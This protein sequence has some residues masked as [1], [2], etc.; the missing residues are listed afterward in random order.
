MQMLEAMAATIQFGAHAH[1]TRPK[2]IS[3]SNSLSVISNKPQL[4]PSLTFLFNKRGERE[5]NL[6]KRRELTLCCQ[7]GWVPSAII[8]NKEV[9]NGKIE[10]FNQFSVVMK[11]G[12][13]SVASAER[14]RHVADLI[15][16]YPEEDPIIVLS[17][18]GKTT[19]KLLLVPTI[20]VLL[21]FL[22]KF[23]HMHSPCKLENNKC[24]PPR[25]QLSFEL[26]LPLHYFR[27]YYH[28]CKLSRLI[29]FVPM[30]H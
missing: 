21:I 14:M 10:N 4:N 18:M 30:G 3:F 27:I 5:F 16:S 28:F 13:S 20:L 26:I 17:A 1:C 29:S 11:F 24:N 25:S 7:K 12:G 6:T 15:L 8:D 19:N 22:K 9:V 2:T 23:A